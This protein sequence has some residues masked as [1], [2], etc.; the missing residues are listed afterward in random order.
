M[1]KE[2]MVGQDE[3]FERDAEGEDVMSDIEPPNANQIAGDDSSMHDEDSTSSKTSEG[4]EVSTEAGEDD[5]ELAAFDAKIAQ[6]LGARSTNGEV[7][8][9]DDEPSDEDMDDE[10]MEALDK[11]LEK[12]FKERKT[13]ISKNSQKKDA[14]EFIIN[15]KCRVLELLE[16]FVKQQSSNPLGLKLLIPL[17]TAIRTTRSKLVSK[18]ACDL[19]RE[20]TRLCKGQNVPNVDDT[21]ATFDL[22]AEI[23]GEAMRE[24]SHAYTSACSQASLLVTKVLV[25][26]DRDYLRRIVLRYATTQE[27]FLFDPKCKVKTSFFSDWLNWC[28]S[29]RK[30]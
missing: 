22:L 19:I 8:P 6:A 30:Q 20:Y 17:L 28:N 3:I 27:R 10:Q 29:A 7:V 12:V 23:H 16:V 13:A 2:S 21:D 18:K 5:D 9:H 14:K 4:S 24:G 1:A 15:F 26:Q 11:Q 25:A